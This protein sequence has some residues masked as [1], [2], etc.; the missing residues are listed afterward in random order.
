MAEKLDYWRGLIVSEAR[1]RP[2]RIRIR[3]G[4]KPVI[5]DLAAM[6][7]VSVPVLSRIIN[8]RTYKRESLRRRRDTYEPDELTQQRIQDWLGLYEREDLLAALK[9]AEP[10]PPFSKG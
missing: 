3:Q 5:S 7:K 6:T 1:R 9:H 10:L 4:G 2:S 8:G